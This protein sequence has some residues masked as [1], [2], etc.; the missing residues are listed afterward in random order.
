MALRMDFER[1]VEHL[2][3]LHAKADVRK[4]RHE[5]Q[6]ADLW[7]LMRIGTK[8]VVQIAKAQ[9]KTDQRLDR[10]IQILSR[11]S[12]NGRQRQAVTA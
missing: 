8:L 5:K 7:K 12:R 11:Q 3:A 1:A 2:L 6:A 10:L 4:E 9:R